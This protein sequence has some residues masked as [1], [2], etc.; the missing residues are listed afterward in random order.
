MQQAVQNAQ[1]QAQQQVAE[2]RETAEQVVHDTVVCV[3]QQAEAQQKQT[4]ERLRAQAQ[5]HANLQEEAVKLVSGR[6]DIHGRA[7][8]AKGG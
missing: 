5:A 6:A 4:E 7:A 8:T 2:M 3:Q 1:T